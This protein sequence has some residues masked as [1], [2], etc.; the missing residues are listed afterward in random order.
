MSGKRVLSYGDEVAWPSSPSKY[1]Y[2][3][4]RAIERCPR[5]WSLANA[6]YP[7][8]WP[9][10]GYPDRPSAGA[11]RGIVLHRALEL[12]TRNL[13]EIE[14][15]GVPPL[16]GAL[17]D[18]GGYSAV[19]G[20]ALDDL[21]KKLDENPRLTQGSSAIPRAIRQDA[22]VLRAQLQAMSRV[23]IGL[24][25]P[26]VNT[27][28]A[29]KDRPTTTRLGYGSYTEV[30]LESAELR[31]AGQADLV[32]LTDDSVEIVDYKTGAPSPQHR[33]QL[34]L[35]GLLWFNDEAR[36]PEHRAATKLRAVYPDE[37]AAWPAAGDKELAELAVVARER[38]SRADVALQTSPPPAKPSPAN[39]NSCSVRHLCDDYWSVSPDLGRPRLVD[40]E[41]TLAEQVS[42]TTWRLSSSKL[43]PQIE[44]VGLLRTWTELS[45]LQ[46]GDNLRLLDAYVTSDDEATWLGASR[47]TEIFHG[48]REGLTPRDT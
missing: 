23:L 18:F 46:V 30:W 13:R 1:S 12:L 7:A 5:Q 6:S 31:L 15:S 27:A 42:G 20:I 14:P 47:N 45:Q 35:Y 36:N 29:T 21:E 17:R 16:V 43:V 11:L 3:A 2:S 33:E 26:S 37:E 39:C 38:V 25:P 41:V 24:R 4:L 32:T 44:G 22:H 8:V 40:A 19:V 28:G 48:P 10:S 34:D 9:R